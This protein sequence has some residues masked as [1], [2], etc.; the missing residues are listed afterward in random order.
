MRPEKKAILDEIRGNLEESDF[1]FL[2]DYRGLS[3]EQLTELR[4]QLRVCHTKLQ[5]VKNSLTKLAAGEL[6]LETP[7][8]L[9]DGPVAMVY[10]SGD[11][12][13]VA[14][15]I[16]AFRKR[17]KLPVIMGGWLE[18]R[19]LS[20]DAAEHMADIPP[21]EVLLGMVVGTVCAP[22]SQ[23]V[24]VMSQ[25]LSSLLYVLKAVEEKKSSKA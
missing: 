25:K 21:R 20:A 19:V 14:K 4:R 2:A 6:D 11:A 7:D 18:R 24:G 12:P 9:F 8:E 15:A 10:G 22:M 13:A 1:A 3:V 23:L 17:G 16:R 5:V